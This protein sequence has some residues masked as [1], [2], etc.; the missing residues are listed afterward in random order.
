MK[1]TALFW[2]GLYNFCYVLNDAVPDPE[3]LKALLSQV[4]AS[5][6]HKNC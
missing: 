2:G 5:R 1:F 3:Y 4:I 6:P